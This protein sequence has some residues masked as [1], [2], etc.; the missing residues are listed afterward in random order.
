MRLT[1]FINEFEDFPIAAELLDISKKLK[2]DC[3]QFLKLLQTNPVLFRGISNPDSNFVLKKGHLKGRD[4]KDMPRFL[5]DYLICD[6]NHQ[7]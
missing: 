2:K 4:P 7:K 6:S 3:S 5:H 1:K